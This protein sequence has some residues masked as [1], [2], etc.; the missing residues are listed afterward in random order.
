M[1]TY[2]RRDILRHG[3]GGGLALVGGKMLSGCGAPPPYIALPTDQAYMDSA[4]VASVR[5]LDLYE[6]TRQVIQAAGGMESVV[7]PGQ[8]VF[9]KPNFGGVGFSHNNPCMSG[10]CTKVEIVSTVAEECLKAG[11]A[12]VTIGEG[13]Q[14]RSFSWDLA[15]TLDGSTTMAN[16]AKRLADTYARPVTLACLTTD[17][18]GWDWVPSPHTN[19]GRIKVS[20]LVTRADRVISIGVIKTHRWTQT[21]GALKNFVG[22]TSTDDYGLGTPDRVVLHQADGGVVQCFLDIAATVNPDLSIMDGSICCEGNGPHVLPGWWGTTIDV[23]DRLGDW[24]LLAGRDPVAVD[25]TATRIIGIE[26]ETVDY[27]KRANEQGLGQVHEE[28]IQIQGPSI[29][30]LAVEFQPA[31]P[32]E[33]FLGVIIPGIHL[34]LGK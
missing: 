26:A 16:E 19:L 32:T 7:Q 9:I 3:I 23:K 34:L 27:L 14:V 28:Q 25:A 1:C 15:T 6:M 24:F 31:Q 5:G 20:N 13:G 18:P 12:A 2:T 30:D 11:A 8:T 21:T 17:S 4:T 22:V 29:Q 10:E 33:G